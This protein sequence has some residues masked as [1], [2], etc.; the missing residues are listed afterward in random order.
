MS[1]CSGASRKRSPLTDDLALVTVLP[2]TVEE[3]KVEVPPEEAEVVEAAEAP[4]APAA[5]GAE[6]P[7]SGES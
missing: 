1:T 6:A 7:E 4:E 2:P 3:V 5:A